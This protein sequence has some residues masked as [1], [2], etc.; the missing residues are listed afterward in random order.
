MCRMDRVLDDDMISC[1]D[2][3]A[4]YVGQTGRTLKTW[5]VEH[6]RAVKSPAMV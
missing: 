6:K 4:T 1:G 2:C 5:V 3:D